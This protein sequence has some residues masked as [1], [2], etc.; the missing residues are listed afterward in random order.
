MFTDAAKE[1]GYLLFYV[2]CQPTDHKA[3]PF[4]E[5]FRPPTGLVSDIS[6]VEEQRENETMKGARGRLIIFERGDLR[7]LH[8]ESDGSMY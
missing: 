2:A 4:C 8:N 5:N 7:F 1:S 6:E 3:K